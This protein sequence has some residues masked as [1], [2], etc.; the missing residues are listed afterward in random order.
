M[1]HAAEVR[2]RLT[3]LCAELPGAGA[4][5]EA[6]RHLRLA[7]RDRTF[8][9]VVDDHHADGRLGL[10]CKAAPG[11]NRRLAEAEPDLFFL[12]AYLASKGW[13]GMH[14]DGP[15][16]PGWERIEG[17]VVVSFKLVAPRRLAARV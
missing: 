13:V 3:R 14:L 15:Q 6:G 9:W 12:P 8:A 16:P 2:E 7:V 17:L 10:N 11:E 4:S 5:L 1:P